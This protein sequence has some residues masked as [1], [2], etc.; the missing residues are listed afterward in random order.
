MFIVL[1]D[2]VQEIS[3]EI[4]LKSRGSYKVCNLFACYFMKHVDAKNVIYD[5]LNIGITFFGIHKLRCLL[6]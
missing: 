1:Q 3:F 2:Q 6:V 4:F 5:L